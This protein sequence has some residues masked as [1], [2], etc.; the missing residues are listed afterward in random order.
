MARA[1]L[2][3][4]RKRS[5][6]ETIRDC[7]MLY[8]RSLAAAALFWI[9]VAPQA[10]A[11]L[12]IEAGGSVN[13]SGQIVGATVE[14]TDPT[15]TIVAP[16]NFSIDGFNINSLTLL[17]VSAFG[18]NGLLMDVGS[19]NVSTSG[20]GSL[21]LFFIETGLT[22]ASP[23]VLSAAFTASDFADIAVTRSIYFD[24][25]DTGTESQLMLTSTGTGGSVY[26]VPFDFDGTYALIE[27]IDLT[28]LGPGATLNAVDQVRIP[29]PSSLALL[30]IG[31][32]LL[33]LLGLG[34][35]RA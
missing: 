35:T 21:S 30:L 1:L 7:I 6:V 15:N 8:L 2:W 4:V 13:G 16:G 27:E 31:G 17:G 34:R 26:N 9:T 32:G 18:G 22:G 11:V 5:G 3:L 33:G 14:G 20:T 25:T 23:V 29:E 12:I 28:A 19:L 10:Q 24:P